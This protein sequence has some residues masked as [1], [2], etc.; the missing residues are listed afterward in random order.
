MT[1]PFRDHDDFPDLLRQIRDWLAAD[2][3]SARRRY[4]GAHIFGLVAGPY[5][6]RV[7]DVIDEYLDDSDPVK[8]RVAA[9]MLS[10]APRTL[11]WDVGFVRRCLRAADRHGDASLKRVRGALHAASISG[12]RSGTPGQPY[13]EDVEQHT[14]ATELVE[15]CARG[16]VEEQF[17]RDLADFALHRIQDETDEPS[18]DGR[19]W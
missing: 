10:K 7:T 17:Y 4:L 2:P 15:G 14:K 12:M 18:A 8:I 19:D 9:A 6:A 3:E 5:D 16:S 1:P 13:P 11:V